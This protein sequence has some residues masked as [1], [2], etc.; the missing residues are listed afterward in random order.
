[1]KNS[2]NVQKPQYKKFPVIDNYAVGKAKCRFAHKVS[3]TYCCT[4]LFLTLFCPYFDQNYIL[5]RLPPYLTRLK[6]V[7][8]S[9]IDTF[10]VAFLSPAPL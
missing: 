7:L 8:F 3:L 2:L 1:M 10:L 6:D 4:A 9:L 5:V